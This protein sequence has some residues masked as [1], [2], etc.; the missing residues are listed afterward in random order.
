MSHTRVFVHLLA[1]L[2]AQSAL[3]SAPTTL[4]LSGVVRDFQRAHPD[5]DVLPIGGPGHY[6]NNV[7]LTIGATSDPVFAGSGF[8]VATQWENAGQHEIAPHM[9]LDGGSGPGVVLLVEEPDFFPNSTLDTW[10]SSAGPYGPG[11]LPPTFIVGAKMPE[12]SAPTG[13]GPSEG[14]VTLGNV[15][16]DTDRH[17]DDLKVDG[18]V[19]IS[20]NRVIYCEDDFELME[21]AHVVLLPNATLSLY[22][23]DDID[24][25]LPHSTFNAPPESGMPGRAVIYNLGDETMVIGSPDSVIYA[26]VIAPWAELRILPLSNFYGNFIGKELDVQP[27]G[28]LHIDNNVS[29][30]STVCGVM[31][32]DTAGDAGF[33]GDAAITSETTYAQ[34]YKE[35]LGVNLSMLHTIQL[36]VD[37]STGVY[38]YLNGSFYPIDGLGYGNEDDAHNNYFTFEIVAHFEYSACTDQFIEF[39][40]AD[41]AWIF[42]EQDMVIDLGGIDANTNQWIDID[43]LSL[44]DGEEYTMRLFFAH[45]HGLSQFNLRTNIELW[46]DTVQVTVSLPFD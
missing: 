16:I 38:E 30:N 19:F 11:G 24:I 1:A 9:Y 21:D 6:A 23:T 39:M 33:A 15:L 28:G 3:A 29:F 43:R 27:T 34:W 31:I 45:R 13:L 32:N 5:F 10:D 14:D 7:N 41:D 25:G 36:S 26:T 17:F 35:I 18:Y 40:G 42:I 8:K 2:A 12:I 37:A 44:V 22:I 4:K 46:T 20:G